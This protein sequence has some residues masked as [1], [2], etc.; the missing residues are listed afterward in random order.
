MVFSRPIDGVSG[1]G[2]GGGGPPF[3]GQGYGDGKGGGQF[4]NIN[5]GT[6]EAVGDNAPVDARSGAASQHEAL[7]PVSSAAP[8]SIASVPPSLTSLP[9]SLADLAPAPSAPSV[10]PVP[11]FASSTREPLSASALAPALASAAPAVGGVGCGIA[12]GAT[13]G[14]VESEKDA[15]APAT[16]EPLS[17]AREISRSAQT[18]SEDAPVPVSLPGAVALPA[19]SV[20]VS[21]SV[22]ATSAAAPLSDE[23]ADVPPPVIVAV[24]PS[25]S[26]LP[27][28]R[29][30]IVDGDVDGDGDGK[31]DGDGDGCSGGGGDAAAAHASLTG[32]VP[33]LQKMDM[34]SSSMHQFAPSNAPVAVPKSNHH[35][36]PSPATPNSASYQL[37]HQLR[38]ESGKWDSTTLLPLR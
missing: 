8:N 10:A 31:V 13:S 25:S 24:P 28:S 6:L 14:G 11:P 35:R 27:P 15:S 9:P 36:N 38:V 19:S 1:G 18:H 37:V 2:D 23:S 17:S 29:G 34:G 30:G 5:N 16:S 3:L 4:M 33:Q 21:V 26:S 22:S 20:S 32:T 7:A 12:V